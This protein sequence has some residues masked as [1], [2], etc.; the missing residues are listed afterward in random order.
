MLDIRNLPITITTFTNTRREPFSQVKSAT[1]SLNIALPVAL[2][3]LGTDSKAAEAAAAVTAASLA[4][5]APPSEEQVLKMLGEKLVEEKK[6]AMQ[7]ATPAP[8]LMF[9]QAQTQQ[10]G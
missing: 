6:K 4:V 1:S 8:T 10:Q 5:Q 9:G 3:P 7:P 2:A